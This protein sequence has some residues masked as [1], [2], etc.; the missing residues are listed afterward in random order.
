MD[1]PSYAMYDPADE[2]DVDGI[3]FIRRVSVPVGESG[4]QTIHWFKAGALSFNPLE[5]YVRM[6]ADRSDGTKA[7]T[8]YVRLDLMKNMIDYH[9]FCNLM[10]VQNKPT[11]EYYDEIIAALDEFETLKSAELNV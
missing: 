2:H 9:T 11:V 10:N 7:P 3:I 4:P 1:F 8:H 6:Y 5:L